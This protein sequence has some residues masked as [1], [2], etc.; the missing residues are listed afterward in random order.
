VV[1]GEGVEVGQVFVGNVGGGLGV[2]L[3][4]RSAAIVAGRKLSPGPGPS[5]HRSGLVDIRDR[6]HLGGDRCG[7]GAQ[8][9]EDQH[10]PTMGDVVTRRSRPV[11]PDD[12][13]VTQLFG[14]NPRASWPK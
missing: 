3:A 10:A 1:L 8:A 13:A 14:A 5:R 2:V 7:W 11:S 4:R 9:A 12:R 6:P